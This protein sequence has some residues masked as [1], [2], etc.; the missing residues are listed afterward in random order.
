MGKKVTGLTVDGKNQSVVFL[1]NLSK[2]IF[3]CVL[4]LRSE[5]VEFKFF[6]RVRMTN[7]LL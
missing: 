6:S 1:S 4:L 7:C 2:P 3:P 5:C